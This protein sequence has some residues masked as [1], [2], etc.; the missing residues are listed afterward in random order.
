MDVEMVEPVLLDNGNTGAK[1]LV[2]ITDE[3]LYRKLYLNGNLT[4]NLI[5][6]LARSH[7]ITENT[8]IKEKSI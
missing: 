4:S 5:M 6:H 1:C 8:D 2:K 7:L 3:K